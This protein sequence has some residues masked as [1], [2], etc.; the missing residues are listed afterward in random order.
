MCLLSLCLTQDVSVGHPTLPDS[1]IFAKS[2]L[3]F[4]AE[5]RQRAAT[6]KAQMSVLYQFLMNGQRVNSV[7]RVLGHIPIMVKVGV[8]TLM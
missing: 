5:C 1:N 6:Y 7:S 8:V 4:P 3:L 2:V